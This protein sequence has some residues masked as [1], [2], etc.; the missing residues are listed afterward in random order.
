MVENLSASDAGPGG[1]SNS[2]VIALGAGLTKAGIQNLKRKRD[3]HGGGHGGKGGGGGGGGG[4]NGGNGD[5][6][7]CAFLPF[8]FQSTF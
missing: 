8:F 3:D 6:L 7:D 1:V 5:N 4:N 2:G